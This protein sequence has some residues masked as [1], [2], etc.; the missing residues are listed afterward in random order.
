[1][2]KS[3]VILGS[4]VA[5]ELFYT[6][7]SDPK[8]KETD[9]YFVDDISPH[10][11]LVLQ[12]KSYRIIKDW[13]FSG[14][15][16][17][18]FLVGVGNPAHKKIMIEKALESGL[19]PHPTYIHPKVTVFDLEV[20][21][22]GIIAENSFISCNVKIGDFVIVS[23]NVCVGHDVTIQ[24]YVSINP[25]CCLSG[26]TKIGESS[27]LGSGTFVREKTSIGTSVITGIGSVVVSDLES[28]GTYAG[29]PAKRIK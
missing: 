6:L 21:V 12:G 3:L 22:G 24:D 16:E 4:N 29:V 20:G 2:N 28:G 15:H 5:R 8:Y 13:D 11:E 25:K 19:K 18:T 1:M 10:R 7:N 14:L 27:I 23:Y 9:F 17:P 26:N